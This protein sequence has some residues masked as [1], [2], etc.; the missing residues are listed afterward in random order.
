MRLRVF[1][2]KH[3]EHKIQHDSHS[4]QS[5]LKMNNIYMTHRRVVIGRSHL[6]YIIT[7]HAF[8]TCMAWQLAQLVA[9]SLYICLRLEIYDYCLHVRPLFHP[10]NLL[11]ILLTMMEAQSYSFSN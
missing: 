3:T 7:V 8:R 4:M 5:A 6:Q 1:R 2:L 9:A 10:Q 11:D